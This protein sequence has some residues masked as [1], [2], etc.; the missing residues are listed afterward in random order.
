[1]RFM[2]AAGGTGGHIFPALAV[3][4]EMRAVK[5]E[6]SI[7][8]AGT[9]RSRE[10]ELCEKHKIELLILK[11]S[12]IQKVFSIATIKAVISFASEVNTMRKY[13]S[14]NKCDAV[15]AFGGY[16]SAPVITA[17]RLCSVPWFICEQNAVMGRVNRFF[18]K[19]AK[20]AFLSFP[21]VPENS[22]NAKTRLT[23]MPVKTNKSDYAVFDYPEGFDRTGRGV[24][25]SGGSQG[26]ASMNKGLTSAVRKLASSGVQVVWQ[27][28][29]ATYRLVKDA[30]ASH[31]NV[32][33]FESLDDMYPYYA[34][35]RIVI[36][37]AGSSTINEAAYFGLPCVMIPLPWSA[38]NHQWFNAGL[39]ESAGWGVRVAQEGNFG[40]TAVIAASEILNNGDRYEKMSRRALDN[41]PARAAEEIVSEIFAQ[42]GN[43]N[44]H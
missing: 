25:V 15:V 12:G 33:V 7:V 30:M 37:R 20:C 28:G 18:A 29:T 19:Q 14:K 40:E 10:R 35:S 26:A 16:V 38:D 1:M 42:M 4:L 9:S 24:L 22:V 27:T 23:G 43:I 17:A 36:C 34:K 44:A 2:I 8:W 5:P 21:L 13:F 41:T 11:V 32:F 39:V 3:A 31:R 6:T